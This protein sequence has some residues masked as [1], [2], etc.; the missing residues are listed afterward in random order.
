MLAN[1]AHSK[2]EL[3][4]KVKDAGFKNSSVEAQASNI[5]MT[6]DVS[7]KQ[8]PS[9]I[10]LHY[11]EATENNDGQSTAELSACLSINILLS[12]KVDF[13]LDNHR[14]QIKV[15]DKP[16]LF[17]NTISS[18]QLFTRHFHKNSQVKK[19]N[20]TVDKAWLFA[21]CTSSVEREQIEDLFHQQHSVFQWSQSD[22]L[23]ALVELLLNKMNKSC[24]SELFEIEQLAFQ[25]FN[26]CFQLLT[27]TIEQKEFSKV[28]STLYTT[29]SSYSYE[30][31]VEALLHQNLSLNDIAQNLGASISTLQ[32]Y[33][34]SKHQLPLKEYIRNQKL[35]YARRAILFEKL[36]IGEAAYSAGYNHVS[37]FNIAFKKYFA[38]TPSE[39]QK[40]YLTQ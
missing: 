1:Q 2:I 35:E 4:R 34:K 20:M 31:K 40:K 17:I 25:L 28:S 12:G 14:Y 29:N 8:L 11:T 24:F 7:F 3:S 37:N 5:I 23:V 19:L 36:T 16:L 39:L 30:D 22:N 27:E 33:F 10:D 6:G 9:G 18:N 26:L 13:S 15:E 21:R 32:R 38:M